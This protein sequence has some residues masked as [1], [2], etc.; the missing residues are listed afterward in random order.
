MSSCPEKKQFTDFSAENQ[1][2]FLEKKFVN[3]VFHIPAHA[4]L[5]LPAVLFKPVK[6]KASASFLLIIKNNLTH[7]YPVKLK[8][9]GGKSE[10]LITESRIPLEKAGIHYFVS[11]NINC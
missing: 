10:V 6:Y 4:N 11:V 3:K 5:T 1:S 8:G 9:I 2:F 7:I